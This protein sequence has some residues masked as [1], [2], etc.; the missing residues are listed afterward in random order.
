[1]KINLTKLL[2]YSNRVISPFVN[3]NNTDAAYLLPFWYEIRNQ[4]AQ[5]S[6]YSFII[7]QEEKKG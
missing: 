6:P 1:M 4:T 7:E 5:N 2:G 3:N